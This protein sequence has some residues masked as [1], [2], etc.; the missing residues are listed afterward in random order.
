MNIKNE[1]FEVNVPNMDG[2]AVAERVKVTVPVRWDDEMKEWLLT[3]KAHQIIE[4][5]KARHMG[6]L[7][8]GQLKELRHRY[9][10]TQEEMGE[11]FQI[12]E[13]SWTR[14]ETGKQRPSRSINLLIRALYEGEIS[15]NYL[16]K[17]AGKLSQVGEVAAISTGIE[18]LF[19]DICKKQTAKLVIQEAVGVRHSQPLESKFTAW[20]L[21]SN[22]PNQTTFCGTNLSRI[23]KC[24][25]PIKKKSGQ[26]FDCENIDIAIQKS[27]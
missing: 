27:A 22:A 7:L 19:V 5:T 14:W 25:Q 4:D 8:P 9:N 13:K 17:R 3:P 11:L 12:G 21:F 15:V 18:G 20:D 23:V 24:V 1:E 26:R 2:T 6:L 10:F 16:L